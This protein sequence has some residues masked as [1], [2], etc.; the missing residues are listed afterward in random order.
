[1]LHSDHGVCIIWMLLFVVIIKA[2]DSLESMASDVYGAEEKDMG[3][4]TLFKSSR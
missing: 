4:F 1:M 3:C 2:G